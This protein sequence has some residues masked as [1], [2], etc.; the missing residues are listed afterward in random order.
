M[1]KGD[2][3]Q[4]DQAAAPP[5]YSS[6]NR[7][8]EPVVSPPPPGQAAVG[9]SNVIPASL[10]GRYPAPVLCPSCGQV[11]ITVTNLQVGRGAHGMAALFF[12]T[13][14]VGVAAPYVISSFKDVHHSC[15]SCGRR[16]ATTY[17]P[18]GTEVHLT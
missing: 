16:I 7:G 8:A 6:G 4:D 10:L 13:T 5:A 17:Y 9:A 3:L 11:A 2:F 12:F 1:T 18:E 15:G 14:V